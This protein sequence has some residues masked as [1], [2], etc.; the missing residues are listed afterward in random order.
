MSFVGKAAIARNRIIPVRFHGCLH[1]QQR[2]DPPL[3]QSDHGPHLTGHRK[4]KVTPV[5][6][7][8]FP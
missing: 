8:R 6:S 2:F 5:I 4:G 3:S 7:A 1:K